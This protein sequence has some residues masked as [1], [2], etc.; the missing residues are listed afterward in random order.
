VASAVCTVASGVGAQTSDSLDVSS[1]PPQV[2]KQYKLFA[3]KCSRCHD[4]SR[5]LS[6]KYNTEAQWREM[7]GRMARKPGAG[8]SP[9]AQADITSFLVYR[10]KA[11]SGGSSSQAAPGAVTADTGSPSAP[12]ATS[13]PASVG[14]AD[15]NL[16]PPVVRSPA[17]AVRTAGTTESG[18]LRLEVDALPA[19]PILALSE[20][21]WNRESPGAGDNLF[22]AVRVFDAATGEKV[23]YATIMARVGG[24]NAAPAKPLRPLFGANGFQYG[25]NFAAPTGDL[26]V[27]LTVEPPS[28]GRVEESA[29]RW[30]S[31]VN[32]KLTLHGR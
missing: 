12:S 7:V 9:K 19:Q 29:A 25:A 3:E 14:T 15:V 30:S 8:I 13:P 6:A 22:L 4:L 2:Q 5:P 21:H 17:S 18:G 26:E 24:E 20:G 23:P 1:Y 16:S 31:P 27:S 11:R 28:V 10:Q 32:L